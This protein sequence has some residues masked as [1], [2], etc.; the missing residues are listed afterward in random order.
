[1]KVLVT[2]DLHFDSWLRSGR[3]PYGSI[4]SVLETLDAL[5]IAGDIADNPAHGWPNF[6]G[7]LKHVI[8]PG[9]VWVIPGNHD[10][11]GWRLDD[12]EGLRRIA[13]GCGVNVAQKRAVELEGHR[14]LCCTLWT[15]FCLSG[16]LIGAMRAVQD[17]LADYD[18][19]TIGPDRL[20][21]GPSDT[22][23]LHQ[24]HLLW[25][26]SELGKRYAGRTIVVTHHAPHPEV[27]GSI[28]SLS[29]GFASNLD[30]FIRRHHPDAWFFGHTHRLLGARI[31]QGATATRLIN[32]SLGYPSEVYPDS[33]AQ[34]RLL[35]GLIMAEEPRKERR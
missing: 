15:D 34:K 13:E 14:F 33:E 23:D 6:F 29:A 7:W 28:D 19:I 16:D 4:L 18:R 3:N 8:D 21:I 10:Y 27:A 26:E 11:Y 9:K 25:L 1:M 32:I 24:D 30:G 22:L 35:R 20:P 12:D 17:G 31:G 2:A 5:I